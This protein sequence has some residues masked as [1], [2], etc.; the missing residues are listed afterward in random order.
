MARKSGSCAG[1]LPARYPCPS[2]RKPG[3]KPGIVDRATRE[4]SATPR[5]SDSEPSVTIRAGT[6]SREM[7]ARSAARRRTR[8]AAPPGRRGN[9]KMSIAVGH[10]EHH[11]RE[12]HHRATRQIDAADHEDRR[13]RHRQQPDLDAQPDDFGSRS[14]RSESSARSRQRR[15]L[16]TPTRPPGST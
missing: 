2:H 8:R 4:T 13:H 9:W 12:A 11:R 1:T 16:R 15:P 7:N 5:N 10:A 6:P 3:R 14:P